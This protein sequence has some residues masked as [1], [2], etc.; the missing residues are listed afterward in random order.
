ML[1]QREIRTFD[2]E[3]IVACDAKC[4]KAWG[5]CQRPKKNLDENEPDDFYFLPDNELGKAPEDPG[6][7]EGGYAKPTNEL[8]QLNKWC[9]RQC[10]RS[11][12]RGIDDSVTED[13]LPDFNKRV[14]NQ[15][16]K[17]E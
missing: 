10:E 17:H 13:Y 8:E 3:E 9:V 11:I 2:K 1:I 5:I 15:P 4:N 16:W 7:Y 12:R 6:E 14:Y